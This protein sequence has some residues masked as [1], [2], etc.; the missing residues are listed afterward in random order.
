VRRDARPVHPRGNT[1]RRGARSI[2]KK[3]TAGLRKELAVEFE[4]L[5]KAVSFHCIGADAFIPPVN[6]EIVTPAIIYHQELEIEYVKPYGEPRNDG[7]KDAEP[8]LRRVEPLHHA[9]IDFGWYLFAWDPKH[10]DVRTFALRRMRKI[11]MTG[12][13]CKPRRFDV[14]K[15]LEHSFGAFHSKN[16]EDIRL[17]LWG[18]AASVIP[19]FLWHRSQKF[20]PVPRQPDKRYM[21]MKVSVNPRLIGWICE[22]LGGIAVL[23]PVTLREEVQKATKK[24]YDDQLRIGAEWDASRPY[25]SS[26]SQSSSSSSRF[27]GARRMPFVLC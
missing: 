1:I 24:G 26:S 17:L 10:E 7:A 16:P 15:Q 23:E 2:A 27:T 20:E 5:E 21:T 22:W 8:G 25:S 14:N 4:A 9:C 6:F 11:R 19:E 18:R 12:V 3:L 13:T